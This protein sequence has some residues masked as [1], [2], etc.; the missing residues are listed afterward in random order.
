MH[1][2]VLICFAVWGLLLMVSGCRDTVPPLPQEEA[3]T[4]TNTA[5]STPT[6]S[7]TAVSPPIASTATLLAYPVATATAVAP[8]P[9]ATTTIAPSVTF[10]PLTPV[11]V[12]GRAYYF[13][14]IAGQPLMPTATPTATPLP[15][16]TPQPTP[17]PIPILD[18][19]ALR[20]QLNA[21][22][23]ALATV[24][25]GF[26]TAVGGN[27]AG[28]EEWMRQLDAAG[29]PFFLKSV[30]NAQPLFFAQEL[31]KQ[32]GVPHTLV[33]RRA[34]GD[35]YDVPEYDLSPEEAAYRHWQ[36][37]M[38]VWPPELDPSLVW[39]ETIN[40]VDKNRSE[41]LGQFALATAELALA[42]G[43]KWAAFG[44]SSGEPEP[45][46]WQTPA[47]L[48]FLRLA[49]QYPDRLGIA[50]H[51]YSYVRDDIGDGYPYK[52]GRFQELFRICDQYGIPRPTVLITEWGWTYQE[53]PS[54]EQ[55][56]QDIAWASR[57]YAPYPQIKGAAIW[58]LGGGFG[59]IATGTQKLIY[60]VMAY[61]LTNY[62]TAPI[63]PQQAPIA[64]QSYAPDS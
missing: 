35:I 45:E 20:E 63:P 56:M 6:L 48:D 27:S 34:T 28:L 52:I 1:R 4:I 26:H 25:I 21:S 5:V 49:A 55:A 58:Y 18:F 38:E 16:A 12:G 15:T 29:I 22:G 54:P 36:R 9:L 43:Y 3:L 57:L 61:T 33:F 32:S 40:E 59:G 39:I 31:M 41:W 30:D 51:E 13:P 2:L 14:Y 60:P 19:T 24:K 23:Q 8:Y 7:L 10:P 53:V 11:A 62:F 46:H 42:D 17:T 44:W 64:P 47:M 37:H 50:L